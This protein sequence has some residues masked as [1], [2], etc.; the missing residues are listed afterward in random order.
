[1]MYPMRGHEWPFGLSLCWA[2][3]VL[4]CWQTITSTLHVEHH[5]DFTQAAIIMAA[6]R[7]ICL[8]MGIL[9]RLV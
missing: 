9:P 7:L 1:M 6:G 8:G 5:L 2:S 3:L 4:E